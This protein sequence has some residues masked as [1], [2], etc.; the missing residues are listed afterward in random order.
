M[1]TLITLAALTLISVTSMADYRV[2]R[3]LHQACGKNVD[4][5]TA[6]SKRAGYVDSIC[7]SSIQ[8][9]NSTGPL[10]TAFVVANSNQRINYIFSQVSLKPVNVLPSGVKVPPSSYQVMALELQIIGTVENGMFNRIYFVRAP[11]KFTLYISADRKGTAASLSGVVVPMGNSADSYPVTI[12]KFDPV[13][14]TL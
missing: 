9:M 6:Y 11:E 8:G 1:K 5:S 12:M 4:A 3:V 2:G 13:F 7:I 10:Y 14:S